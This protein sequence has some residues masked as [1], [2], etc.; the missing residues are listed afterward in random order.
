MSLSTVDTRALC[1]VESPSVRVE[2]HLSNGLP[3]FT[4]V[5]LPEAAVRESRERVRCA[6]VNCGFEFPMRR[7]TVNLA[8]ADLPKEGGRYDLAIAIGI[9]V[10]SGQLDPRLIEGCEFLAELALSGVCNPVRG[11][12]PSLV[13]SEPSAK[14]I[15]VAQEDG[16]Y[17]NLLR[18]QKVVGVADLTMLVRHL[19]DPEQNP[20]CTG[21]V[22]TVSHAPEQDSA[23]D[24]LDLFDVKGQYSA[25]KALEIAAA[26]AHNLLFFGPPGTGKS[27]L[28]SRLI[29]IL[30]SLSDEQAKQVASLYT[31]TNAPR[32][33]SHWYVPPYRSPHHSSSA[34]SLAGG[35]AKPRPGEVSLAHEGVLFLDELPEFSRHGLEMLREPIETGK[36]AISRAQQQ[37]TLPARFQL[38]AAMNPC[39]C[40]YLGHPSIACHCSPQQ[41]EQYRRKIS[42][43]LLDRIDMHVEVPFQSARVTLNSSIKEETSEQIRERVIRSRDRQF[44]RQGCLNSALHGEML[45][46]MCNLTTEQ[47]EWLIATIDSLALSSRAAHRIMRLARTLADGES[48]DQITQSHL[49]QALRYR[50]VMQKSR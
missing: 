15:F 40:G 6:M 9:L 33:E 31:L 34:V 7:V 23:L 2:T 19:R 8:P 45:T 25:K 17:R 22:S 37:L 42:G 1:G 26:G 11:V 16:Q 4:I 49:A 47:N 29:S 5:G 39:P 21:S 35:G 13:A 10:A 41:V 14:R 27:M 43:P 12:L 50:P 48:E 28:A 36:I 30:P 46:E 38:I 20:I 18:S 32:S 44:S 24:A 3:S